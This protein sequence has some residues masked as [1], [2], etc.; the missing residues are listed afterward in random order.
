MSRTNSPALGPPQALQLGRLGRKRSQPSCPDAPRS[1]KTLRRPLSIS[2]SLGSKNLTWTGW[3]K[4]PA[5]GDGRQAGKPAGHR[6]YP[7]RAGA[8]DTGTAAPLPSVRRVVPWRRPASCPTSSRK[9]SG[10]RLWMRPS[11]RLFMRMRAVHKSTPAGIDRSSSGDSADNRER[12][13]AGFSSDSLSA[14]SM[15]SAAWLPMA[16]KRRN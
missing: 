7:C 10:S 8:R 3:T 12:L 5:T 14:R 11:S 16:T 4:P 13:L 9:S 1:A 15:A 2:L 6:S